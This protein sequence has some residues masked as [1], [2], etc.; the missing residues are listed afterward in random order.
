MDVPAKITAVI[1]TYRRPQLL[2]RAIRSVLKQTY[3]YLRVCVYDNS[4]NDETPNIVVNIAKSDSRVSYFCH[5][6]NI[7]AANNF[8]FGFNDVTTEYFTFLSDDDELIPSFYKTAMDHLSLYPKAAFCALR[9]IIR[10]DKRIVCRKLTPGY[11]EPP[12]GIKLL[13]KK[14]PP[15]TWTSI[16]YNTSIMRN[17]GGLDLSLGYTMDHEFTLRAAIEYPFIL[18]DERGSVFNYNAGSASSKVSIE[19]ITSDRARLISKLRVLETQNKIG[20]LLSLLT[21]FFY[22]KNMIF[23]SIRCFFKFDMN[24]GINTLKALMSI[25]TKTASHKGLH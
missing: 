4:S 1:P 14:F 16:V 17:V 11:Y 13:A 8:N 12:F 21:I 2:G 6:E 7:G 24:M 3:P 25:Y 9:T 22:T 19:S 23:Q 5:P 20:C 18:I 10:T 15:P